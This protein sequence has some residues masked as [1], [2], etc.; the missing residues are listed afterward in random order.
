MLEC[1]EVRLVNNVYVKRFVEDHVLVHRL[2]RNF[3]NGFVA[4]LKE[5]IPLGSCSFYA[6]RNAQFCDWT[7]L[8]EELL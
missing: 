2:R 5:C 3:S 6:S 4:K 8:R 7:E 1:L